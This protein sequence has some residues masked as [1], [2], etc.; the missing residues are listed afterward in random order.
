M[1]GSNHSS[2]QPDALVP[3]TDLSSFDVLRY[4]KGFLLCFLSLKININHFFKFN[5][6]FSTDFQ[7]INVR[8]LV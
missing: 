5:Q 6:G 8:P 1:F 3:N 2:L 7:A 4:I